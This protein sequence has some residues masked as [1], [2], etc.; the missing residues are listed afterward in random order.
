M[1]ER[2]V[3]TTLGDFG[4]QLG[5][6]IISGFSSRKAE[7]LLVYLAV[8]RDTSHRRESLFTLLWPWMMES[9]ARNN[10]RQVLFSLRKTIPEVPSVLEEGAIV[11]F[12]LSDRKTVR[13]HPEAA[14]DVDVQR[15]ERL[16]QMTREHAHPDLAACQACRNALKEAD[17]ICQGD[18]LP[19]FYLEDSNLFEDWA[20][21]NREKYRC[22]KLEILN[23]LGAI[24]IQDGDYDRAS[25]YIE[26]QLAIDHL[27]EIAHRQMMEAMALSGRRVEAIRQY[28]ECVRILDIELGIAPSSETVQ[29]YELLQSGE[30]FTAPQG[31]RAGQVVI[32]QAQKPPP[33]S[34]AFIGRHNQ[35][36][37]FDDLFGDPGRP[38]NLVEGSDP[39]SPVFRTHDPVLDREINIR[40]FPDV[41]LD[42]EGTCG[43]TEHGRCLRGRQI[44]AG[45]PLRPAGPAAGRRT[46]CFDSRALRAERAAN[47]RTD[48]A[49][50][51]APS[52]AGPSPAAAEHRAQ[53][54]LCPPQPV[55]GHHRQR[56]QTL[57][58]GLRRSLR[59][60][61]RAYRP[62]VE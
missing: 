16:I 18:F 2:L 5:E 50:G 45:G 27:Q 38:L 22:I 6:E 14:L 21:A 62:P 32:R 49:A 25:K 17:A 39:R 29:L 52:R 51:R 59:H 31:T 35:A 46:R 33:G 7:A 41:G 1:A 4:F 48:R 55:D 43:C 20:E 15:L 56:A 34:K 12:L 54:S 44:V 11:P 3:V 19:G 24:S 23:I 13:V 53:Q 8:E 36:A 58:R 42:R 47:G 9:A 37:F 10:L 57:R 60:D 40:F 28:H 61:L 26:A 30:I